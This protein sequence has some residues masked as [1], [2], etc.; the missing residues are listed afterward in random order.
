MYKR[1]TIENINK[2]RKKY[3][4]ITRE[5]AN[6]RIGNYDLY[7]MNFGYDISTKEKEI[8]YFKNVKKTMKKLAPI[9]EK[10]EQKRKCKTY[11]MR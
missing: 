8:K 1:E 11:N 3:E 2:Q 10:N 7:E 4:K 9:I 5:I 6:E